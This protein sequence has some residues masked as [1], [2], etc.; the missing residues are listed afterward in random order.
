MASLYG[1]DSA[2]DGHFKTLL[3]DFYGAML[4]EH[5]QQC[6]TLYHEDD[7]SL[8]EISEEM[9]TSPQAVSDLLRRTTQKLE[10]YE[11]KLGLVQRYLLQLDTAQYMRGLIESLDEP[12]KKNLLTQ[13]DA[14]LRM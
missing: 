13:L 10:K 3:Y 8:V 7:C 14:L 4:T 9:N 12:M 5:Q 6:F 1:S 11:T 2:L